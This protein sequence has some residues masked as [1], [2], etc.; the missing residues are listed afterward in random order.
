MESSEQVGF[1]SDVSS[2][3]VDNSEN[4]H[5]CLDEDVFNNK[6]EPI[7]SNRVETIDGRN[8]ITKG[9]GTVSWSRTD[10]DGQL[11]TNKLNNL[12]YFTD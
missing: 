8:I 4:D 6:I 9:I 10:D 3:I 2:F 7:I 5:I 1:E 12:I 11:H